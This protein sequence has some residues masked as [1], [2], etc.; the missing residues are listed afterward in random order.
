VIAYG[1]G[2]VTE[3]V[4]GLAPCGKREDD[5]PPTGV[6]FPEQTADSLIEAMLRFESHADE[7]DPQLL[8]AHAMAFDTSVFKDR[9]IRYTEQALARRDDLEPS[10]DP[11]SLIHDLHP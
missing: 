9:F 4:R 6:F 10:S 5:G 7:F 1:A 2:G 8:R 11:L 3:T